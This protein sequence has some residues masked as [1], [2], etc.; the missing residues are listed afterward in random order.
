VVVDWL[1]VAVV[2]VFL[3]IINIFFI[4]FIYPGKSAAHTAIYLQQIL[5]SFATLLDAGYNDI[6]N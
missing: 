4:P 2:V 3:V 5:F 6:F 1:V